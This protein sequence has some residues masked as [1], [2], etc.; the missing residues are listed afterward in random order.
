[1]KL[2]TILEQSAE[3]N[4]S[5][6]NSAMPS[7][8]LAILISKSIDQVDENLNIKYFAAAVAHVL[9]QNYGQHNYDEFMNELHQKLGIG[10]S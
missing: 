8:S 4:I 5:N 2:K 1:M 7:D 3:I 6:S 9:S 10:D